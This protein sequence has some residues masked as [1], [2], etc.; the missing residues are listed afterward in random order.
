MVQIVNGFYG[1]WDMTW[2]INNIQNYMNDTT[3]IFEDDITELLPGV[4]TIEHYQVKEGV[5]LI[6]DEAFSDCSTLKEI[7]LPHSLS[8]IGD[9]AFAGC[10]NLDKVYLPD[11][12]VYIGDGAFDCDSY[13]V[14]S[15]WKREHLLD[16]TIPPSIEIINGNPFCFKTII[17]CNNERFKVIDNSIYSADGKVLISCCTPQEVFTVPFGV[18]RI[19]IGAFRNCPIKKVNLPS[20]LKVI[21]KY[22]FWRAS[23]QKETIVFPES[24]DEIRDKAFGGLFNSNNGYVT[25]PSNITRIAEDAF[26]FEDDIQLIKVPKG[27]IDHYKSI[28]PE[29]AIHKLCDEDVIFENGLYLSPDK[30]ELI[31]V[32]CDEED[33]IIP[34]GVTKIRD[35]AFG[36]CFDS[37]TFP[38]SLKEF[39]SAIFDS[40]PE[41]Y[42]EDFLMAEQIY[43]PSGRKKIFMER[44]PKYQNVIEE[45]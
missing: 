11:S 1:P 22:A 39:T 30:T 9:R 3:D 20:T 16:I 34:E 28:L 7:E 4:K 41:I 13:G 45:I 32:N 6:C 44:L 36:L 33:L 26:D 25:F 43:V 24:L 5:R 15:F 35:R 38:S 29:W 17:H 12:L 18:E 2:I 21:D 8:F 14:A 10:V 42:G 31:K 23:C 27:R 40:E 37:I 19:G